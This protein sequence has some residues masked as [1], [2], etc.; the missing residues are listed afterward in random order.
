MRIQCRVSPA[1]ASDEA[2]AYCLVVPV[3]GLAIRF[4][5]QP[6]KRTPVNMGY[7]GTWHAA[8]IQDV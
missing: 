4:I 2:S 6:R 5:E 8:R 3:P 7:L 1:A